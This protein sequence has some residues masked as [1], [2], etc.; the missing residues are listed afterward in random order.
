MHGNV[1]EWCHD[2]YGKYQKTPMN[3][4]TGP[5]SG[6]YRVVRGGSWNFIAGTCR[7]TERER[8][9]PNFNHNNLGFRVV[10]QFRN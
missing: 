10:C 2:W 8:I 7:S 3:N 4:P 6:S 9:K 5:A 1:W